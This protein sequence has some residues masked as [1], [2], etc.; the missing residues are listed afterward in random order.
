[1]NYK[2]VKNT[3]KGSKAKYALDLASQGMGYHVLESSPNG[4]TFAFRV[5]ESM[6]LRDGMEQLDDWD[7][8]KMDILMK[9]RG[10]A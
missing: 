8:N 5:A 7:S 1:M 4:T 3:Y 9:K 10:N 6:E 2:W